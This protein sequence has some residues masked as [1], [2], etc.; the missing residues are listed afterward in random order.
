MKEDANTTRIIKTMP[1]VMRSARARQ[2]GLKGDAG[3]DHIIGQYVDQFLADEMEF[4]T[5]LAT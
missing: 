4:P 1:S 3:I 2:L 5:L